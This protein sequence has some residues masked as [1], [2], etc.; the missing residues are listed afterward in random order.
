MHSPHPQTQRTILIV[1]DEEP[2]LDLLRS[3]LETRGFEVFTATDQ[4]RARFLWEETKGK[5]DIVLMDINLA[6]EGE[7]LDFAHDLRAE[8]PETKIIFI[9]GVLLDSF[10]NPSLVKGYN[11]LQKP[12]NFDELMQAVA[13][14]LYFL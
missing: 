5:F 7:G 1:D 12:F 10:R 4:A 8:R 14:H 11:F 9:S 3:T 2:V 6:T 13:K